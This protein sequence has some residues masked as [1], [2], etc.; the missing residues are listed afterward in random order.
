MSD[1]VIKYD[2]F[3]MQWDGPKR[4]MV[5]KKECPTCGATDVAGCLQLVGGEHA[6]EYC[7]QCYMAWVAA[8]VPRMVPLKAGG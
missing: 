4:S 5:P 2:G 8:N 1:E 6:G 3:E 7:L